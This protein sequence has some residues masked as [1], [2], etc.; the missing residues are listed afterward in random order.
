MSPERTRA[1][2]TIVERLNIGGAEMSVAAEAELYDIS[3]CELRRDE[4]H[5]QV[6]VV[7]I[8]EETGH[9]RLYM[10]VQTIFRGHIL[11]LRDPFVVISLVDIEDIPALQ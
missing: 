8:V 5:I 6:A 3:F 1:M 2:L 9:G 11:E 10:D 4:E 7:V